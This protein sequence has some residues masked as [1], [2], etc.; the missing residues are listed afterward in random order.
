MDLVILE[1]I[2]EF[3]KKGQAITLPDLIQ[4]GVTRFIETT[5]RDEALSQLVDAL[6]EEGKLHDRNSF[7]QAIISR[8]KI[9]STG[10]GM[11]VAIPHAKLKEYHDFFIAVGVCKT[12]PGIEWD[13][14]DGAP[15]K[16]IFMIGG[17]ADQQTAYLQILSVLTAAIKDST[18]QSHL[19]TAESPQ[20]IA[21]LF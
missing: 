11:G 8:E 20:E 10:V 4:S 5:D 12:E 13:A 15:V 16:L 7:Y 6:D 9:V 3:L 19:F 1:R 21:K 14:L 17:P 2:N 18:I